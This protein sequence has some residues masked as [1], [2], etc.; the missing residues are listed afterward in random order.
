MV[1][2]YDCLPIRGTLY[3]TRGLGIEEGKRP[4][5]V[6]SCVGPHARTKFISLEPLM[7]LS[8]IHI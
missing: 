4:D 1:M 3:L 6:W 5:H 7:V 8:L 2:R